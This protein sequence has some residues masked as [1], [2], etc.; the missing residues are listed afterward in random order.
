MTNIPSELENL[1]NTDW[2]VSDTTLE[3]ETKESLEKDSDNT[4]YYL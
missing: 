4:E 1:G 2:R 3:S